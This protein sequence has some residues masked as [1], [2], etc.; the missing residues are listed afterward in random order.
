MT[1]WLITAL[2]FFAGDTL[3]DAG[4][5]TKIV[6]DL[7]PIGL[8]AFALYFVGKRLQQVQKELDAERAAR[9]DDAKRV[10]STL[11]DQ[12]KAFREAGLLSLPSRTPSSKSPPPE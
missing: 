1:T 8:L 6:G 11:I 12:V 4:K 2:L 3:T 10:N 7:G 9:L 5:V